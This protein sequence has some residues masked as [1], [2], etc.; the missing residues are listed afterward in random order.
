MTEI[1]WLALEAGGGEG[2]EGKSSFL[3]ISL[4][5]T[6]YFLRLFKLLQRF[7]KDV[8]EILFGKFCYVLRIFKI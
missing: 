4:T 8:R 5:L 3:L 2:E 6:R 1:Q 7:N